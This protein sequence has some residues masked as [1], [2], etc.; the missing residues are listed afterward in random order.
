[1]K[2]RGFSPSTRTFQTLFS[3]LSRIERWN[4]YTKQLENARGIYD[5]FH[6]HIT[7]LKKHDAYSPDI[8]PDPLAGYIKI[9]GNA[10]QYQEIFDVYYSLDPDGP[11]SANAII[12]TSV[13]Q[14]LAQL[15]TTLRNQGITAPDS[16]GPKVA[17]DARLIWN[18]VLKA[19]GD[20]LPGIIDTPLATAAISA[21]SQGALA[22]HELAFEIVRDFF[23][24]SKD[25]ASKKRGHFPLTRQ[26]LGATLRLCNDAKEPAL[27][28]H[29]FQLVKRSNTSH[30]ID[31]LHVEE[32]IRAR[33][34]L[35]PGGMGIAA[36]QL[37]EWMLEAEKRGASGMQLRPAL[38]TYNLVL[39]SCWKAGDYSSAMTAFELMTGHHP[40]DFTDSAV[41][42]GKTPRYTK[43]PE[44]RNA[45]PSAEAL[46]MM[47]RTAVASKIRP[48][49]R[50]CLRLVDHIGLDIVL[51]QRS[52]R[53][54]DTTRALKNQNFYASKLA[55]AVEDAWNAVKG[56]GN[57]A[58]EQELARWRSMVEKTRK[59]S[60]S[61]SEVAKPTP[62]LE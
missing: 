5:D 57:E 42:A 3:G 52:E 7:S 54:S 35:S 61:K 39:S 32:V 28:V 31:R 12:Y 49:M 2:R 36:V 15:K 60:R 62:L 45:F 58:G 11:F 46:S 4:T 1:M 47:M 48:H 50:A 14:A 9:L 20:N 6:K 8:T 59:Y 55:D 22:D 26:A 33:Y 23:G 56:Y 16:W 30:I 19:S 40:E 24:L 17:S 21:L 34:H 44:G 29:F 25:I 43:R 38:S 18:S 53:A 13:L 10:G 41:A 37:L 51:P 27:A